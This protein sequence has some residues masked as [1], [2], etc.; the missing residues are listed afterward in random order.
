MRARTSEFWDVVFIMAD[1][2]WKWCELIGSEQLAKDAGFIGRA[3]A[4]FDV[5]DA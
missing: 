2:F 4:C 5:L 1:S 3:H